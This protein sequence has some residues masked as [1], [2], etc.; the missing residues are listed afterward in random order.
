MQFLAELEKIS[1]KSLQKYPLPSSS[2]EPL[3][4][5]PLKLYLTLAVC[6]QAHSFC[7]VLT[8]NDGHGHSLF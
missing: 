7:G 5:I 6:N 3:A 8:L 1:S 4:L 2:T